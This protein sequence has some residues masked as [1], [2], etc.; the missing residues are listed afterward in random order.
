MAVSLGAYSGSC[1]SYPPGPRSGFVLLRCHCRQCPQPPYQQAPC[2]QRKS[3]ISPILLQFVETARKFLV[4]GLLAAFDLFM[5]DYLVLY[6]KVGQDPGGSFYLEEGYLEMICFW[7]LP[8]RSRLEEGS[9]EIL[10]EVFASSLPRGRPPR[11][12]RLQ[13]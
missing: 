9:F 5:A 3:C 1:L 6:N 8:R 2:C 11:D 12:G 10:C 4:N 13:R 7:K